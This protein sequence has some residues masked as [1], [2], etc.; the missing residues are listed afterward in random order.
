MDFKIN[1]GDVLVVIVMMGT[2]ACIDLTYA[3]VAG[4]LFSILIYAWDSSNRVSVERKTSIDETLAEETYHNPLREKVVTK[5]VTYYVSGP[6]FFAT[7]Q[8]FVDVFQLEEIQFDPK[9]VIINLEGAEIFDSSGMI[10]VKRICDRFEFLEKN[11]GISFLS[12]TS[13]RLM[14]KNAYM[15]QGVQFYEEEKATDDN[16]E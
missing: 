3:L 12:E 13:R 16:T 8:T 9:K 14:E 1:R 7:S 15:W 2:T 10:A 11:V 6:L 4:V 5:V